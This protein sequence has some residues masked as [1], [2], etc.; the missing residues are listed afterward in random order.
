MKGFRSVLIGLGLAVV[1]AATEYMAGVDWS[2]LGETTGFVVGGVVMV[3]M[4]ALTTTPI[5]TKNDG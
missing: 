5:F 2:F 1:P 4:R 3:V